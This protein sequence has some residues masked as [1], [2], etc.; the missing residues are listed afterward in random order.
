MV[1]HALRTPF[2]LG[3]V[4]LTQVLRFQEFLG[5]AHL[6]NPQIGTYVPPTLATA[7][8]AMQNNA[9]LG[10]TLAL[11]LLAPKGDNA[12][13]ITRA[14]YWYIKLAATANGDCYRTWLL[15][16]FINFSYSSTAEVIADQN[17]WALPPG[18]L[19][20][21]IAGKLG[22]MMCINEETHLQENVANYL[23]PRYRACPHGQYIARNQSAIGSYAY[24]GCQDC[25]HGTYQPQHLVHNTFQCVPSPT[26]SSVPNSGSISHSLCSP[27][28]FQDT[29]GQSSCKQCSPGR[30]SPIVASIACFD[31]PPGTST[32]GSVGLAECKPCS[33]GTFA[34]GPGSS[35]CQ[36]CPSGLLTEGNGSFSLASCGC[37]PQKALLMGSCKQCPKGLVC[38]G[39][40]STPVPAFGFM[41]TGIT[42]SDL[43]S[44][45]YRCMPA[46][47]CPGGGPNRCNNGRTGMAYK[48][49]PLKAIRN[50]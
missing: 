7:R 23:P 42:S 11:D 48:K 47:L 13:P 8:N 44:N 31:C 14:S 22:Q 36:Q 46:R 49:C 38:Y 15:K 16:S 33:R 43:V 29:A 4:D 1:V 30:Y 20:A 10:G 2:S 39:F 41:T 28:S 18:E 9:G 19:Q 6:L 17:G 5:V 35:Q 24:L 27:G 34:E 12:Y 26:G 21:V 40:R 50:D 3:Y 25:P 32:Q 37:L 45:L